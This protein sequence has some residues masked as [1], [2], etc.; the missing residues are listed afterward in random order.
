MAEQAPEDARASFERIIELVGVSEVPFDVW[1]DDDGLARRMKYE[2][3]LPT[4]NGAK[5]S[6]TTTM[7]MYDFGVEVNVEPPPD[8][9]VTD[10]Q[11]LIQQ[12]Q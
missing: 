11:E 7:E 8:D 9:Q 4:T 6:M 2:Q 1:I 5:G 10:I 3:P 12:G